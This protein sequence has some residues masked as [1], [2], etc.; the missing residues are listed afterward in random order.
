M[1]LAISGLLVALLTLFELRWP[2]RAERA[3]RAL[4]LGIWAVRLVVQVVTASLGLLAADAAARLGMVS[5]R[6]GEWPLALSAL[7]FVVANDLAEYLYHRAQHAIPWLWRRHALHHSDPCVSAT[8]TER[9]WWGDLI[10]KAVLFVGP[11]AIVLQ[12]SA[13]DYGIYAAV[14]LWNYVAH[15]NLKLSFGRWSWVLNSPAYHRAHHAR[16]PEHHGANFA[17]LFP[18]LDVLAGSY[19]RPEA[20]LETGLEVEPQGLWEALVWPPPDQWVAVSPS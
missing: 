16:A 6:I 14:T 10:L 19:R 17:A 11:L 7:L 9:H 20:W 8:T 5:L 3:P 1:H 18:I 13:A 2:A 4:N 12:P 15:A